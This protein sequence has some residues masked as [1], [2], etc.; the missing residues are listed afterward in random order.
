MSRQLR[1]SILLVILVFVAASQ[2][3]TH[4]RV[5]SWNTPLWVYVYPIAADQSDSAT[6][7]VDGLQQ[8]DFRDIEEFMAGEAR[9]W[10]RTIA[11]PLQISLMPPLLDM[12]PALPERPNLFSIM[13]WS[14]R[15]RLFAMGIENNSSHPPPDIQLFVR[16]HDPDDMPV[17]EQSVGLNKGQIGMINAFARRRMQ[18]ANNVIV[19]H[20]ML[21]T[22][23]AADKYGNDNQPLNPEGLANPGQR[24]LYPQQKA[25]IMAVRIA[26]A[27][28][29]SRMPSSL[30]E[31]VIGQATAG[32]IGLLD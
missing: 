31:V 5:T 18:G 8:R 14:A 19:T 12:P 11:Q 29:R 4:A 10:G 23:G 32:E 6:S 13:W 2:W 7:Y 16:Y 25:E 30:G 27:A 26:V 24:P 3:L 22:L 20:E 28:D 1:I 15:M 21:H 9:R 17:L